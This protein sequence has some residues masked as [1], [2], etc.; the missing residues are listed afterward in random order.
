MVKHIGAD[1]SSHSLVLVASA[2]MVTGVN[3]LLCMDICV[4]KILTFYHRMS[5]HHGVL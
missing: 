1:H 4:H 3:L 2:C 5:S